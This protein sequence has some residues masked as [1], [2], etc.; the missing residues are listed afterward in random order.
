MT[1]LSAWRLALLVAPLGLLVA[2]LAAQRARQKTAV[3]F[4]S[5]DMLA[6]VAPRRPG[7]QRHLPTA[8]L[9]AALLVLIV[10]FA[11]PARAIRTPRQRASVILVLDTSGSMIADDVA[12]SRL[13]AA[14][15]GARNFAAALPSGVQLGL[16]SFSSG[17][18]ML[19][20][21]T[22]DR[23]SVL[24]AIDGL[25]SGGGTATGDAISLALNAI[26][27]LP[28][29]AD[30]KAA[31]AAI[32]LMSDGSPTIGT[33]DQSPT[34]SAD[35]AASAAKQAGVKI[36][37]IAYGTAAGSIVIGGHAIPVP[38]DPA[39]MARIA[40]LSGGQTFTAETAGQLKSVYDQIGRAV[41]YDVHRREVTAWFTGLG[42]VMA[43]A[44]AVAA[45]IWTQRVA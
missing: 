28:P 27:T 34:Q 32:V 35:N 22:T 4:T 24:A 9:L 33:G 20:P 13:A 31:P 12:P 3:R 30:G 25:R 36:H 16:E 45:L 29:A 10:G 38:A 40:A 5:V 23:A 17:A 19:V 14:Q 2:Y 39:A 11:Q 1:F 8:A 18:R 6:S 7:W 42:L 41:G 26:A 43:I 15:Q 44:G 37:T 21:P